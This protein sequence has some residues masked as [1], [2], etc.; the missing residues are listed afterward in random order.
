MEE[1]KKKLSLEIKNLIGDLMDLIKEGEKKGGIDLADFIKSQ[2]EFNDKFNNLFIE[3][4]LRT[5]SKRRL[6]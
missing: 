3:Y 2:A 5:K 1:L 6:F 4:E